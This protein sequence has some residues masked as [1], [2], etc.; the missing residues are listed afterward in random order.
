MM[1]SPAAAFRISRTLQVL[2]V[3]SPVP[4]PLLSH[5]LGHPV[6]GQRANGTYY[7]PSVSGHSRNPSWVLREL[8]D[9]ETRV[10]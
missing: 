8:R 6:G 2:T 1:S 7:G 3:G 5:V 9:R 4:L 10:L